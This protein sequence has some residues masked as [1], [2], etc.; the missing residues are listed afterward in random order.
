MLVHEEKEL[1]DKWPAIERDFGRC[2]LQEYVDH[3]GIYYNV[4]LYRDKSGGCHEAVI[5]R[6]MRYFP[7]KGGPSC[8]CETIQNETLV[9]ICK[10]ILDALDWV[11]FA[12]F[13]IMES[14]SGEYKVIEIN[15]RVPASI[16]AAYIAGVNY[17]EMIVHD[18]K[19]E[20]I[21]TYTY[22]IGKVLRFWGLDVMWFI[23]SP[24]RF[25]SHPSWFCFLGKNIFYQD[26]SLKDPLPML[27]GILSGLVKYLNPSFRKS[28]LRS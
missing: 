27:M 2:T 16:H 15:P 17:P 9:C 7:L 10:D 28:K 3:T 18:M 14:K 6:I 8:Y 11:G 4:M 19:D 25:S 12:D 20:P 26:G 13:D 1:L 22:H 5:I 21:L 23:F 24:Q